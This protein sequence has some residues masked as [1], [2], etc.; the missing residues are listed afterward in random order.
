MA[1]GR[2]AKLYKKHAIRLFIRVDLGKPLR[3]PSPFLPVVM[4]RDG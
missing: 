2:I 3:R 4:H 1:L